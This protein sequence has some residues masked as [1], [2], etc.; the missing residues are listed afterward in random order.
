MLTH[1]ISSNI[2]AKQIPLEIRFF[3]R[4]GWLVILAGLLSFTLWSLFAPLDKGVSSSGTVMV[5]GH[6][7]TIQAPAGGMIAFVNVKEGQRVKAGDKLVQLDQVQVQ[8]QLTAVSEQYFTSLAMANRLQAELDGLKSIPELPTAAQP[9][10]AAMAAKILLLQN[11]IFNSRREAL[12]HE[13][14]GY[15][16]VIAGISAQLKG[17]R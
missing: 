1:S 6:R 14:E 15:K 5:S 8:A 11:Q 17:L 13:N 7:K 9:A 2:K 4:A 16:Q 10:D 3:S 12:S